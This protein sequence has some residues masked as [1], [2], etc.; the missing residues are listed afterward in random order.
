M[1]EY[2]FVKVQIGIIAERGVFLKLIDE[3]ESLIDMHQEGGYWDFKR[4]W[5]GN[6]K[7]GDMLIDIICMANNLVNK[8]AYIIIGVDEENNYAILDVTQDTN[9]RNTQMLTDFIRWKKFAGDFR[10]VVTVEQGQLKDGLIDVIVVHNSTNTPYFLKEKYKGVFA[11]NIYVRL[12]DSNTPVDKSA[13]FHQIEYLWKKRF[14]M[15][16]SPIEKVKLYLKKSKHWENSPSSKDKKYY[17]YAPEFTIEHTYEPD[18]G[19]E[20]YEYY[21]F[22]QTDSRPHWCEIRICYHQ[23]ILAEF[24]GVMLDGGRYFTTTP[25]RNWIYFAERHNLNVSYRYMVKGDLNYLVHEFYY[26]DDGDEERHAH[27]KYEECILIF[28]NEKE[29]QKF[30]TYVE[31]NWNKKN[32]FANDIR[33]PY[34]DQLPGYNM[35]VFQEEYSNMQ[36]LRRMLEA[37]REE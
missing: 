25:N 31:K 30:R 16:L 17:K 7:D 34:M 37:F 35:N 11:N 10:P 13:D 24:D 21:L 36:I 23:T 15:L 14:G 20:G 12:Q 28:E 6:N 8:D 18:D 4:E 29:H 3:I 9:R 2:F 1:K 22:A 26:V 32:E 19:R 27:D 33:I 5:Y